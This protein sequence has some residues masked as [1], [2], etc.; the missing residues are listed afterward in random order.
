MIGA[1]MVFIPD[2]SFRFGAL[3]G[4]GVG[5]AGKAIRR[6]PS[7]AGVMPER[8]LFRGATFQSRM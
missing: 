3:L 4:P 7:A 2:A 8:Q 1:T 6:R 5:T